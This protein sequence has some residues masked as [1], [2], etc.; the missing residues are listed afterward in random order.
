[1]KKGFTLVELMVV[2]AII[3]ALSALF[4][5]TSFVNIQRGRDAK[6]KSDL[7][8]IR[9]GIETYRADCNEYPTT[10]L[11]VFGSSLKG[12]SPPPSN[13]SA[14]NTYIRS[15]PNDPLSGGGGSVPTYRYWSD[16]ITYEVCTNL[17][18][19]SGSV[20]CGTYAAPNNCGSKTCNYK[21]TNP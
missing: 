7:E 5:N 11:L 2:I 14:S 20:D 8:L 19:G 15:V 21:V 16:G 4:V 9:S 12:S 10:L 17:E 13:C 6:R 3:G 1:M 18:T